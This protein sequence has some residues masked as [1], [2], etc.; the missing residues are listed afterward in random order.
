MALDQSD[1]SELLAALRTGDGVDLVRDLL[2]L[3]LQ[4]LIEAEATQVIGAAR[5]ERTEARVSERNGHRPK[6]LSTK[7]GDIELGIPKLRRGSFFPLRATEQGAQ[8]P[9]P[10]G[11]HLPTEAAVIRLAGAVLIDVHE[12]WMAAERR[13]FSEGS[14]AKLYPERDDDEADTGELEPAR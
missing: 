6:T 12:K 9:L 10:G 5:Y 8:A 2:R 13:Y 7:A 4:E 14:T 1:L 3:V 11:W